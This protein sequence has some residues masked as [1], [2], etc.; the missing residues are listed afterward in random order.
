MTRRLN[1][2][3]RKVLK[4]RWRGK[5]GYKVPI[6]VDKLN[7]R[8]F[9]RL[10]CVGEEKEEI[11][12][13]VCVG[14]AKFKDVEDEEMY[15]IMHYRNNSKQG[16]FDNCFQQKIENKE[17]D[18]RYVYFPTIYIENVTFEEVANFQKAIFSDTTNFKNVTF[19][20]DAVFQDAFFFGYIS[21]SEVTFN[22]LAIFANCNF[23]SFTFFSDLTF[24]CKDKKINSL[25]S[26][27]TFQFATFKYDFHLNS[28]CNE[29]IDFSRTTFEQKA[30]F[31]DSTFLKGFSTFSEATF[32]D[33]VSFQKVVFG[34]KKKEE[35]NNTSV[36]FTKT[37]FEKKVSFQNSSFL[38][39][40]HFSNAKF[41]SSADFRETEVKN[42]ILFNDATFES[43]VRFSSR[44][45]NHQLWNH[46]GLNFSSVE[47]EKP[48]RIFFQSISLKPDSFVDTDIRKFDFTDIQWETKDFAWDWARF[49]DID[50]QKEEVRIRKT[51]YVSLEKKYRQFATYAEENN[52]YKSASNFRYTAFDIQRIT[53]WYGRL[54]VTLLWWY[55]WTSRYG[56]NWIW[57]AI[58]LLAL[59]FGVFPYFYSQNY[60][61]T[62]STDRPIASSI[63]I[64]E[65]KDAEISKNCSCS[66]YKK[67]DFG[68]A[69]LQSLYTATLQNV[70][71][72][73]PFDWRGELWIILEK[74][75]A[76]LQAALLA[77]A[78][79][80]KFMR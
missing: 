14:D 7:S 36:F 22:R 2:L 10:N 73:K 17:F 75:F 72:R 46:D 28:V 70:D 42:S 49:K 48:E 18:F 80:R 55:K 15:C 47:V 57:C 4:F 51:N 30:N 24:D 54:P 79:R 45:I 61:K 3:E 68:D 78:I 44:N 1:L 23:D 67:L 33:E 29:V 21:F 35:D 52:D 40:A 16:D 13:K 43:Y 63:T 34:N 77:L 9:V 19:R 41:K 37:T 25:T 53:P 65:S 56:E 32:K 5:G 11:R 76:P 69:I 58:L 8:C 12:E 64:C 39:F 20:N 71:Y 50:S 66:E 60:F 26:I 31:D 62:C 6:N 59:L 27:A 74:I 38:F